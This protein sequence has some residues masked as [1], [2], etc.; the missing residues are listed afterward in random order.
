MQISFISCVNDFDIYKACVTASVPNQHENVATELIPIDNTSS[1]L[2]A[3][4]ALNQGLNDAKGDIVVFCHQ[5]VKFSKNWLDK[6]TKQISIV[7]S[8]EKNWGILGSYGVDVKGRFVGNVVDPHNS[9]PSRKLPVQVQSLDEHCLIIRKNSRLCFDEELGGFH[10][11][12][13]DICLQARQKGMKCY[14]IDACVEHLSGGKEDANFYLM[15]EK[16]C[17]KWK[18]IPTAPDIIETTCGVFKIKK[19]IISNLMYLLVVLRR[20]ICRR[21]QRRN[22]QRSRMCGSF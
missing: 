3:A 16:F 9:P 5:D 13:A 12:G 18:N 21:F 8:K 2:S 17:R 15:A 20:K 7:E 19:G 1:N 22:I 10:F 6:L 11:Y 4:A 14:A